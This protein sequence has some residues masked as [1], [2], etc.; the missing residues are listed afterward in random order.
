MIIPKKGNVY[1]HEPCIRSSFY[2]G[3]VKIDGLSFFIKWYK[4]KLT[5]S[6]E[7]EAVKIIFKMKQNIY[8]TSFKSAF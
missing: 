8:F 6:I 2:V 1:I 7:K 3:E 4:V 5:T